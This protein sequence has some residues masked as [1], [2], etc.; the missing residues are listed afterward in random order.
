EA[1]D[2]DFSLISSDA[3]ELERVVWGPSGPPA[4]L[5]LAKFEM[6]TVAV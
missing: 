4:T 3:P 5:S 2:I 6:Q 1:P